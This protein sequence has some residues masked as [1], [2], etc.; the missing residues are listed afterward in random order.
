MIG[1]TSSF[2]T[3]FD[4]KL[5]PNICCRPY[6]KLIPVSNG[7]PYRCTYCYLAF[8]YRKHH[9]FIKINVNYN[10]ML[11]QIAKLANPDLSRHKISF[12]MGEMLDSLALDHVTNLTPILVDFFSRL[13]NAYLMLLTKSANISNLLSVKPNNQTVVS[14][15]INS[16]DAISQYELDTADLN[17]RI[18]AA[19]RCQ[20]HGYR[21]R[22]R[23]DPGILHPNWQNAYAEMIK[24]MLTSTDP[25]NITL[26]M[27]RLVPGHSRLALQAYPIEATKSLQKQ[28]LTE[29]CSDG[30]LRYPEQQRIEFYTFLTNVIRSFNKNVSISLCRETPH[31]LNALKNHC[32]FSTCNCLG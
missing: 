31:V 28:N 10:T 29:L 13:S 26:G 18:S 12:N 1:Q 25:E 8:V 17:E 20:Q 30:K 16:H 19:K 14:W 24:K 5:G 7:C 32:Q 4:G 15:S 11:R 3:G 21:I 22:F 9:P 23:I 2:I 6:Y 27:L